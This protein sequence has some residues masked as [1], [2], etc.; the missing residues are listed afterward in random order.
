M[1][2]SAVELFSQP[3]KNLLNAFLTV[4]KKFLPQQKISLL[5]VLATPSYGKG[6][7][8]VC[9]Y[10]FVFKYFNICI[11]VCLESNHLNK[12]FRSHDVLRSRRRKWFNTSIRQE[13]NSTVRTEPAPD[14]VILVSS[15][16]CF[17]KR[18][19]KFCENQ[20]IIFNYTEC[21]DT[22]CH[23]PNEGLRHTAAVC[24]IARPRHTA[25]VCLSPSLGTLTAALDQRGSQRSPQ[26]AILRR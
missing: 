1:H 26:R 23:V 8:K 17:K 6:E 13:K 21:L 4:R 20:E 3:S 9:V 18:L 22:R 15:I 7:R 24:L 12:T 2:T 25:T 16:N 14:N 11:I 5:A 10:F 19:D